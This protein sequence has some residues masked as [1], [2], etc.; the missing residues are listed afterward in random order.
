MPHS[1]PQPGSGSPTAAN[2]LLV[3]L[4][5]RGAAIPCAYGGSVSLGLMRGVV[6]IAFAATSLSGCSDDGD[7]ATGE[8]DASIESMSLEGVDP[9]AVAEVCGLV[10]EAMQRR[11]LADADGIRDALERVTVRAS[12]VGAE[13]F[14]RVAGDVAELMDTARVPTSELL[15]SRE[16]ALR[17]SMAFDALSLACV[18]AGVLV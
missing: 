6:A 2:G 8:R 1:C 12:E 10:T 11:D 5:R 18:R 17:T 15:A 4:N 9:G 3:R 7:D 14:A 16:R 13:E